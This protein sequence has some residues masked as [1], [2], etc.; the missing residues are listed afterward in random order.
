MHSRQCLLPTAPATCLLTQ[1]FAC[2]PSHLPVDPISTFFSSNV[3]PGHRRASARTSL[4]NSAHPGL[5]RLA[6]ALELLADRG[7]H[8]CEPLNCSER[9]FPIKKIRLY[10]LRKLGFSYKGNFHDQSERSLAR[11]LY[12]GAHFLET[13]GGN[14]FH[15]VTLRSRAF[16][17]LHSVPGHSRHSRA[18]SQDLLRLASCCNLGYARLVGQGRVTRPSD[19]GGVATPLRSQAVY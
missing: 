3:V 5:A 18:P 16:T 10:L 19:K 13:R 12:V 6:R 4:I 8:T 11:I 7:D 14:P 9:A 15:F 17:S 2:L 1:P